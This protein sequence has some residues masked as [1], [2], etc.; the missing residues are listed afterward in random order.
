MCFI[1]LKKHVNNFGSWIYFS[2]PSLPSPGK[3]CKKC[4]AGQCVSCA[5][6]SRTWNW[7]T[8]KE[9]LAWAG[10]A[11]FEAWPAVL[12]AATK[13]T[14]G[15]DQ[16]LSVTQACAGKN[17][18]HMIT[19]DPRIPAPLMIVS[20]LITFCLP[21]N[22][23]WHLRVILDLS[24]SAH[25]SA[26]AAGSEFSFQIS[27]PRVC[28]SQQTLLPRQLVGPDDCS[29]LTFVYWS[30]FLLENGLSSLLCSEPSGIK[31]PLN[32][33][34]LPSNSFSRLLG[35]LRVCAQPQSCC[36]W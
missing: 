36:P 15:V 32:P 6:V 11:G 17:F 7:F 12:K 14:V 22:Q 4:K 16:V 2:S 5:Q 24:C 21:V 28:H 23:A 19:F 1:T 8:V 30:L 10:W 9:R 31:A 34:L 33:A 35:L 27:P 3:L 18:V 26:R 25:L 20:I 13:I 29:G